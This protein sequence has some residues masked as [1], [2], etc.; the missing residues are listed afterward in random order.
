MQ[1]VMG[2]ICVLVICTW[3]FFSSENRSKRDIITTLVQKGYPSDPIKAWKELQKSN[4]P[5]DGD[6]D[7]ASSVASSASGAGGPDFNYL[8]SMSMLS[9]SR[10]KKEEL[11]KER[12]NKVRGGNALGSDYLRRAGR[13]ARLVSVCRD[14]NMVVKHNKIQLRD[15]MT[16]GPAQLAEISVSRC[17]DPG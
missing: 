9:L 16:T 13:L 8:L 2:I 17:W 6:V 10:E 5:E 4:V 15:Y 7:D 1:Y 11:L 12:D 14:L 3:I